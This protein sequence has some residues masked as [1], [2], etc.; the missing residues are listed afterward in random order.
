MCEIL[1][2]DTEIL[3]RYKRV[4]LRNHEDRSDLFFYINQENL[5]IL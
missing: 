1:G 2:M 3:Q 4:P 5:E